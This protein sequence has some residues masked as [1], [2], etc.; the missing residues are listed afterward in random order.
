[1]TNCVNI[2][3][4]S[5]FNF[6]WNR[7]SCTKIRHSVATELAGYQGEAIEV[8]SRQFMK[9]KPSTCAKYYVQTWE[10]R[11]AS[12]LSM[13]CYGTFNLQP[14]QSVISPKQ[15][16]D[17]VNG[18]I[19]NIKKDYGIKLEDENL[20]CLIKDSCKTFYLFIV[21]NYVV[22]NVDTSFYLLVFG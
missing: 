17:W 9:N 4:K 7:V 12:R 3:I 2:E 18:R 13:K 19:S 6:R 14:P 11:E 10:Q 1:M 20:F 5:I 8:V 21:K 16:E 15:V 22:G